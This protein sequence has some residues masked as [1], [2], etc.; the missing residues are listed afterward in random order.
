MTE[1]HECRTPI[2]AVRLLKTREMFPTIID[3]AIARAAMTYLNAHQLPWPKD[4]AF[5]STSVLMLK[6]FMSAM[7]GTLRTVSRLPV[8]ALL[9]A[10]ALGATAAMAQPGAASRGETVAM[11][12]VHPDFDTLAE[13]PVAYLGP[14]FLELSKINLE[15]GRQ[16][17]FLIQF[18]YPSM[19]P[20]VAESP[21]SGNTEQVLYASITTGTPEAIR[22][23]VQ[24]RAV[25][26]NDLKPT[27]NEQCDLREYLWLGRHN[28]YHRDVLAARPAYRERD[29]V[30]LGDVH[31][32]CNARGDRPDSERNCRFSFEFEGRQYV[33]VNGVPKDRL[34]EWPEFRDRVRDLTE[35]FFP[36]ED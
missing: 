27:G 18:Y 22:R 21:R 9:V 28:Y 7:L 20:V 29:G 12:I 36:V 1:R 15:G 19:L 17:R 31:L 16:R 26:R 34:C 13:V 24:H 30:D 25:E 10:L 33:T 35:T 8:A 2:R 6:I 4:S 14:R 32:S 11:T 5:P 23:G 3:L